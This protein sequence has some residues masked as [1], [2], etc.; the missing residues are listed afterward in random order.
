MSVKRAIIG[1]KPVNRNTG[2]LDKPDDADEKSMLAMERCARHIIAVWHGWSV[3][4]HTL[5][6]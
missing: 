2:K 4:Q 1:L 6:G 3:L 5:R